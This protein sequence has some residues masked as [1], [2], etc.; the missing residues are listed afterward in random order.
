MFASFILRIRKRVSQMRSGSLATLGFFTLWDQALVSVS[1]F[2]AMAL[3]GRLSKEELGIYALAMSTFWLIA[4]LPNAIAWI[5]YTARAAHLSGTDRDQFRG[6]SAGLSLAIGVMLGATSI[7]LSGVF[8][9]FLP[10]EKWLAW[11]FVAFAPLSI[12]M[13]L[14]EHVRRVYIADFQG[15]R[16]LWL[17]LPISVALVAVT[18]IFYALGGL[19]APVAMAVTALTAAPALYVSLRQLK[20]GGS[21]IGRICRTAKGNWHYGKWLMIVAIAWLASDGFLRWLLVAMKGQSAMGAFAGAF[22]IVSLV[23][24]ILLAMTSFARS[25]ASQKLAQGT[26]QE[27][28]RGT[29]ASTRRLAI[30]AIVAFVLLYG[31][32]DPFM[33]LV[34]GANYANQPLVAL[35]ALAICLE[36]IAVPMEASFIAMEFGK[37]LSFVA[38]ARFAISLLLGILFIPGQS[39]TGVALA[40]VGRSLLVLSMYIYVTVTIARRFNTEPTGQSPVGTGLQASA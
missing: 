35:L 19:T 23:N 40:M 20:L 37:L 11:F 22:L 24:P 7:L 26:R 38:V 25:A 16:L 4:G 13:T 32:G 1:S 39:A 9:W 30:F 29:V 12:T 6:D 15:G 31:M 18:V 36:A 21:S 34:L 33:S 17:D 3:V 28:F 10:E 5:P 14:R 8:W 2:V 27:L